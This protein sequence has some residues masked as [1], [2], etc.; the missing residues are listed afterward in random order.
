[1]IRIQTFTYA[2]SEIE[3]RAAIGASSHITESHYIK[4]PILLFFL[5]H[6][7]ALK[8]PVVLTP[9]EIRLLRFMEN[10]NAS[11]NFRRHKNVGN[12]YY[13]HF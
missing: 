11:Q 1:M 2:L 3:S 13:R 5:L 9:S 12:F 4:D 7:I 8:A 6:A 10:Q